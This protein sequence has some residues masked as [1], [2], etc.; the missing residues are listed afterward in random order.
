MK[1]QLIQEFL[2]RYIETSDNPEEA[3]GIIVD[4]INKTIFSNDYLC[5]KIR[6]KSVV[7]I[8]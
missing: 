1:D 4:T 7:V 3:I 5:N 6:I 8:S 2:S